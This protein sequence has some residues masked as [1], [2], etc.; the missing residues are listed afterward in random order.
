MSEHLCMLSPS[1]FL[2]PWQSVAVL[3]ADLRAISSDVDTVR[4]MTAVE[5]WINH[6]RR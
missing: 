5:V 3:L 6:A 2:M 4:R 1:S